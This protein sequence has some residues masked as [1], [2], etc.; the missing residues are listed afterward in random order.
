MEPNNFICVSVCLSV[1]LCPIRLNREVIRLNPNVLKLVSEYLY[2]QMEGFV[3]RDNPDV[4]RA[5]ERLHCNREELLGKYLCFL[6]TLL[7][8]T[9]SMHMVVSSPKW[10][11]ALISIVGVDEATGEKDL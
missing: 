10:F 4:S 6:N 5:W 11:S 2:G 1:C 8:A 3:A 9:D 7:A